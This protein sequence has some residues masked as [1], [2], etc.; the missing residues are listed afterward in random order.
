MKQ[1]KTS[2]KFFPRFLKEMPGKP[3]Q[4]AFAVAGESAFANSS[5]V[6]FVRGVIL[7][8]AGRGIN[9]LEM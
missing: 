6:V 4:T 9:L 1:K 3:C 2:L 5:G 8:D 7:R